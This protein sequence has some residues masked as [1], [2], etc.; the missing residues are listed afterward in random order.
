MNE[1]NVPF[2]S[3]LLV[4]PKMDAVVAGGSR[5][6][7]SSRGGGMEGCSQRPIE[8]CASAECTVRSSNSS[9]QCCRKPVSK[10][11]HF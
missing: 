5:R 9:Q 10:T 4:E 1:Q 11:K 8:K 2:A 7:G 3:L 6:R